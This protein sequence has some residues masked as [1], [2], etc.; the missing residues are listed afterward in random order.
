MVV[1]VCVFFL[2]KESLREYDFP[3]TIKTVTMFHLLTCSER[4]RIGR[5]DGNQ[6]CGLFWFLIFV[7][8]FCF[9]N[10]NQNLSRLCLI[11][12]FFFS[13]S[14]AIVNWEMPLSLFKWRF[15]NC[16]TPFY[17]MQ[18]ITWRVGGFVVS[19]GYIGLFIKQQNVHG[20][21]KPRPAKISH[22]KSENSAP[23]YRISNT[24]NAFIVHNCA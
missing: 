18:S 14:L 12:V 17:L 16:K 9:A 24:V 22:R 3:R 5:T 6:R 2:P 19:M 7:F 10:Q 20:K 11:S 4:A 21:K 8:F 15:I 13:L 23:K 1:G